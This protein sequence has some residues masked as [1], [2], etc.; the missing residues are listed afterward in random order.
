MDCSART[1]KGQDC[2]IP[3]D[4]LRQ[5]QAYCHVHDPDGLYCL[6][7]EVKRAERIAKRGQLPRKE[8]LP[9]DPKWRGTPPIKF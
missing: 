8:K 5:G 9:P 7:K 2:P 4:R 1:R 3:A 6:Q